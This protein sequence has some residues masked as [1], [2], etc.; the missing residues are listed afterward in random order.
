M[1]VRDHATTILLAFVL[2]IVLIAL[3]LPGITVDRFP[4]NFQ[5]GQFQS[6]SQMIDYVAIIS[7]KI[8]PSGPVDSEGVAYCGAAKL[9]E[10]LVGQ[11]GLGFHK[12]SVFRADGMD[13]NGVRD[14]YPA[15]PG[16]AEL[17]ERVDPWRGQF[18]SVHSLAE[19]FGPH[20]THPFAPGTLVVCDVHEQ[21]LPNGSKT[22]MP[23]LYYRA[24]K[25][26]T[27][28]DAND[29]AG[30]FNCAD[31]RDL[32]ALGVPWD[33]RAK[34]PLY[35]KPDIVF[36]AIWEKAGVHKGDSIGIGSFTLVSAGQDGLYGTQDDEYFLH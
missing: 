30:T 32:L 12:D 25:A 24:Q 27:V 8:P 26:C 34:H 7:K 16:A 31:N 20:N 3:W 4:P 5:V 22:G 10:A 15:P 14:L 29:L 11:D 9:C 36:Q 35:V 21:E 2:L 17:A 6:I 23:I 1:R 18:A 19:I 33:Q 13:S 28:H